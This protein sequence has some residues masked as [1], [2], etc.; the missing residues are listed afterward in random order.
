MQAEKNRMSRKFVIF[1]FIFAVVFGF[2]LYLLACTASIYSNYQ[3]DIGQIRWFHPVVVLIAFFIAAWFLAGRYSDLKSFLILAL[4]ECAVLF[5]FI[6][7]S[8][9][10]TYYSPPANRTLWNT[11]HFSLA[12]PKFSNRSYASPIFSTFFIGVLWLISRNYSRKKEQD[13]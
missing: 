4:I 10:S 7:G 5:I 9:S 8:G 3:P 1:C 2:S 6:R 11:I 13:R 12:N